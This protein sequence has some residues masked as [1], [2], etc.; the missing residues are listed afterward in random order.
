MNSSGHQTEILISLIVTNKKAPLHKTIDKP[1]NMLQYKNISIIP[2]SDFWLRL[3]SRIW[4]ETRQFK[5][6]RPTE[7]SVNGYFVIFAKVFFGCR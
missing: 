5:Q 2:N 6:W 7:F 1:L 4:L 3:G